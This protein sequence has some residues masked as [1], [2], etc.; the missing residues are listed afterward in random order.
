MCTHGYTY[1][2][3][4]KIIT[5]TKQIAIPVSANPTSMFCKTMTGVVKVIMSATGV[6]SGGT[7]SVHVYIPVK[8]NQDTNTNVLCDNAYLPGHMVILFV[9]INVWFVPSLDL[10]I[11]PVIDKLLLL[12]GNTKIYTITAI[13]NLNHTQRYLQRDVAVLKCL[14][15]LCCHYE[16]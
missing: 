1:F 4:L 13:N 2:L 12:A 9:S 16:G 7:P 6:P 15:P 3:F 5:N 8:C 14:K 11:T 10:V